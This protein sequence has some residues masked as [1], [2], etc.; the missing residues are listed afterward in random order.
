MT[1]LTCADRETSNAVDAGNDWIHEVHH[2]GK[3]RR[4]PAV[5]RPRR[6]PIHNSI[7][8]DIFYKNHYTD[9]LQRS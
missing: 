8:V 4:Y 6:I 2:V 3:C 7:E 5:V 9:R 1:W